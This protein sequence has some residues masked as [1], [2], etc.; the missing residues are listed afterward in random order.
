M[1][2]RL[3]TIS[4]L[5]AATTSY[6]QGR[7]PAVEDFV[8]IETEQTEF[9]PQGTESLFN[10]EKDLKETKKV[11]KTAPAKTAII[12]TPI[13]YTSTFFA[14]AFVLGLPLVSW[15]LVLQHLKRKATIESA[16]NVEVL[17]KYRK[18][19]Q[20]KQKDQSKKAA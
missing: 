14:F 20:F 13:N 1:L 9:V 19:R 17:E 15:L 4:L 12:E 10:F 6:A 3:L 7:K 16:S 5:I 18:E 8:G 11:I 2:L